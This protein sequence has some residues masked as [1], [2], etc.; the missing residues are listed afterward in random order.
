MNECEDGSTLYFVSLDKLDMGLIMRALPVGDATRE[1]VEQAMF[2]VRVMS[3]ISHPFVA[4]YVDCFVVP[5]TD[6][7]PHLFW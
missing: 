1:Y 2:D 5:K 6:K 4:R 7:S 3:S